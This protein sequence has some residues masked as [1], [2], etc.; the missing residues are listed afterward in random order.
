MGKM[1][2]EVKENLC[3][4]EKIRL[5]NIAERKKMFQDLNLDSLKKK[6]LAHS[7]YKKAQRAAK[8]LQ[9][10]KCEPIKQFSNF[11]S[12][13]NHEISFHIGPRSSYSRVPTVTEIVKEPTSLMGI[14]KVVFTKEYFREFPFISQVPNHSTASKKAYCNIC[15]IAVTHMVSDIHRHMNTMKHKKN[16]SAR[17]CCYDGSKMTHMKPCSVLMFKTE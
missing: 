14:R 17:I 1:R 4:M 10:H 2:T 3:E 13:R 12:K 8:K 15:C 5:R 7:E 11:T 16:A 6:F 9:C